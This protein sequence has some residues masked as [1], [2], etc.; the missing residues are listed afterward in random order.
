VVASALS[1]CFLY[2]CVCKAVGLPPPLV[3]T[4][5]VHCVSNAMGIGYSYGLFGTVRPQRLELLLEERSGG[6]QWRPLP[7]PRLLLQ[8]SRCLPPLHFPRLQWS[9]WLAATGPPPH[10]LRGFLEHYANETGQCVRVRR[11]NRRWTVSSKNVADWEE[12]DL[13][14]ILSIKPTSSR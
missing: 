5:L 13:G 2:D 8:P 12:E 14:S 3:V 9:L 4:T 11:V 1:G 10:W 7:L 6:A